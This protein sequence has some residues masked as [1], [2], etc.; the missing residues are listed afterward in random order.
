MNNFKI[1]GNLVADPELKFGNSGKAYARLRVAESRGEGKDSNFYNV[2]AFESLAENIVD[3]LHKGDKVIVDGYF[4]SARTYEVEVKGTVETRIALDIIAN[5][6][7]PSL[8]FATVT[9]LR[10]VRN[11]STVAS[12]ITHAYEEP[13]QPF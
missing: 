12:G 8:R 1:I 2:T 3:S 5:E 6:V 4:D 9:V 13:E 10:N 7:T 11:D